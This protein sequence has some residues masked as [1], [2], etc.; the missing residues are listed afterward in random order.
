MFLIRKNLGTFSY[1]IHKYLLFRWCQQDPKEI[2]STVL[3]CIEQTLLKC[4]S[5]NITVSQI[6]SIGITNQRESTIVWDKNTGEPI[7]PAI[8][9]NKNFDGIISKNRCIW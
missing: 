8:S 6:K 4:Q 3:D 5:K 9:K 7:Y 1:I 2:L